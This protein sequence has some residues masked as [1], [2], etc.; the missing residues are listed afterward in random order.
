MSSTYQEEAGTLGAQLDLCVDRQGEQRHPVVFVNG[1][2]PA[3]EA[4]DTHTHRGDKKLTDT[5]NSVTLCNN[6]LLMQGVALI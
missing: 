3:Q 5:L 1:H 6:L 2:S 4:T